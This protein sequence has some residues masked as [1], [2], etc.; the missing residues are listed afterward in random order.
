[1]RT[2]RVGKLELPGRWVLEQHV[3]DLVDQRLEFFVQAGHTHKDRHRRCSWHR[4][5]VTLF[6]Q[7]TEVAAVKR[8]I[9][10]RRQAGPHL[11]LIAGTHLRGQTE[12]QFTTG[13]PSNRKPARLAEEENSKSV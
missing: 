7:V 4:G 6:K 10:R 3:L 1:M 11:R 5:R 12:L 13:R 9:Q 2:L 8:E